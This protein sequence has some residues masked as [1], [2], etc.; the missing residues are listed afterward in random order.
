MNI[1]GV[2]LQRKFQKAALAFSL[3]AFNAL[4][5]PAHASDGDQETY[6]NLFAKNYGLIT[7]RPACKAGNVEYMGATTAEFRRTRFAVSLA[8]RSHDGVDRI[9]YDEQVMPYLPPQFQ[10]FTFVHECQHFDFDHFDHPP[11]NL[12]EMKVMEDQADCEAVNT[13]VTEFGYSQSDLDVIKSYMVPVTKFTGHSLSQAT[14]RN[15]QLQ[16]CFDK[17]P[18]PSV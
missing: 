15:Q 9:F 18:S 12:A 17:A 11:K 3:V 5:L 1:G 6:P 10:T 14:A 4:A 8:Q 16:S 13:L 7:E 2:N